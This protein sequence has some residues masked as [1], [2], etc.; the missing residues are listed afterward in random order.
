MHKL[1]FIYNIG[2]IFNIYIVYII[3]QNIDIHIL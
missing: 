2:N 1:I 3:I